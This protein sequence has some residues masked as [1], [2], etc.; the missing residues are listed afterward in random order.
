MCPRA[1][2]RVV[3]PTMTYVAF[4]SMLGQGTIVTR[5]KEY[6]LKRATSMYSPAILRVVLWI[7]ADIL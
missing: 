4:L 5:M 1:R 3:R 6:T 7:I 2:P